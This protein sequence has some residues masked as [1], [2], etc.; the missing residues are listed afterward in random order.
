MSRK[1]PTLLLTK[2]DLFMRT[3]DVARSKQKSPVKRSSLL[4]ATG[5]KEI[6]ME[7]PKDASFSQPMGICVELD[8]NIFVT[9][10]KRAVSN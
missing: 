5:T 10:C 4:L 3:Q 8:K 1:F 7:E 2:V 9:T 6:A